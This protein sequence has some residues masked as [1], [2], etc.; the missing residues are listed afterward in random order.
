M[1]SG[2]RCQCQAT[3]ERYACLP[4]A[5][6]DRLPRREVQVIS[7]FRTPA[8]RT[9]VSAPVR[10]RGA[11]A[12]GQ[13]VQGP[14]T[15]RRLLELIAEGKVRDDMMFSLEGGEWR[16]GSQCPELFPP[17]AA[18]PASTVAPLA[19]QGPP[20]AP[21]PPAPV[22]SSR[23]GG[24]RDGRR[25]RY[26]EH[27]GNTVLVLGILGLV[28]CGI[29]GIIAWVMGAA[30]LREMRAGIMDPSGRGSTQAG[31]ICGIIA[32]VFVILGLIYVVVAV[33]VLSSEGSY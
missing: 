3:L 24:R 1:Y 33:G 19:G 9:R 23:T 29:C 25:R 28:V 22:S 21:R 15:Q 26:K 18:S 32:T 8:L 7:G 4:R 17:A 31:M 5:G 11:G 13:N 27:R 30:D 16:P 14:F 6:D 2:P 10:L 12:V 20:S